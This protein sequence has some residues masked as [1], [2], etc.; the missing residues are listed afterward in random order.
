MLVGAMVGRGVSASALKLFATTS[1]PFV[2]WLVKAWFR[3]TC[4]RSFTRTFF[5][6]LTSKKIT[7]VVFLLLD[8]K[9]LKMSEHAL[10]FNTV[11]QI[12]S[13]IGSY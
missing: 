8:I 3:I 5:I 6:F 11:R 10:F 1:E 4:V 9:N 12:F 7:D 2:V 13:D